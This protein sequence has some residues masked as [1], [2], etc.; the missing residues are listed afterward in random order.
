MLMT[1]P[2]GEGSETGRLDD[3]GS[4]FNNHL[5]STPRV[6]QNVNALVASHP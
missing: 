6:A 3:R 2:R 5:P 1:A 4:V